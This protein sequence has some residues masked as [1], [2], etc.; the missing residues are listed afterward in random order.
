MQRLA[1]CEHYYKLMILV[2]NLN[3]KIGTNLLHAACSGANSPVL[4]FHVVWFKPTT[5]QSSQHVAV[6]V[7]FIYSSADICRLKKD[8]IL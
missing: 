8:N 1:H 6:Q 2:N 3:W 5:E 7:V 4:D